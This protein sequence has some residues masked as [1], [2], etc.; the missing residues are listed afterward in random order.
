M[1]LHARSPHDFY[2]EHIGGR[3]ENIYDDIIQVID[4]E[5]IYQNRE[6]LDLQGARQ[7]VAAVRGIALYRS[8]SLFQLC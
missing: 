1:A 4:L 6:I 8:P 2:F 7:I 3:F 5:E